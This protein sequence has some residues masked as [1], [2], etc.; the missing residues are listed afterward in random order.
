[1]LRQSEVHIGKVD[2][3]RDAWTFAPEGSHQFAVTVH[4][5]RYVAQYLRH[6]HEGYVFGANNPALSRGLHRAAAQAY[7][8]CAMQSVAHTVNELRPVMIA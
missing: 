6:A 1:M 4:H 8:A 2:K 7:E 5:P 3:N